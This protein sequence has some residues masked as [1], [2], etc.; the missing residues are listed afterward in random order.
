MSKLLVG[1]V[2]CAFLGLVLYIVGMATPVWMSVEYLGFGSY[3]GLWQTCQTQPSV[4]VCSGYVGISQLPAA[5]NAAR[6]FA[7]IGL[8]LH[9]CGLVL[10]AVNKN[11]DKKTGGELIIAA[12][13][14]GALAG[15]IFAGYAKSYGL[16]PF[17]YSFYLMW[18]Q[19]LF[20]IAGGSVIVNAV[21]S[22]SEAQ[23]DAQVDA[24]G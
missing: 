3:S 11:S 12:G 4:T 21:K 17:G 2:V 23:V 16:A 1:G 9:I 15:A 5:F 10:T 8:V 20:N 24:E 14:S 6:A 22:A 19:A 13:I 18:V 7:V